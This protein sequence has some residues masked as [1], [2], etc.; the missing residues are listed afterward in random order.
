MSL[1]DRLAGA[2]IFLFDPET[3]HGLRSRRCAAACR[4]R[5][6]PRDA[7]LKVS[8]CG[9]DFPTR[10]ACAGYDKNAEVPDALLSSLRLA[11]AGTITPLPQPGNP[12]PRIFR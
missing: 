1:I 2:P 4:G 8:D 3:A 7:R 6:A 5:A 11:E 9:L 10:S 12:K